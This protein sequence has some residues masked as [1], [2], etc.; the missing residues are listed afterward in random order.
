MKLKPEYQ[1]LNGKEIGELRKNGTEISEKKIERQFIFFGDT[2]ID[3]L[4]NH[5]DWKF[6]PAIVIECTLFPNS[7]VSN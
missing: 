6:F 7:Q 3:A 5:D 1:K 4:L 2:S